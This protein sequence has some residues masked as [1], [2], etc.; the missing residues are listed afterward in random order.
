ML[1]SLQIDGNASWNPI[2]YGANALAMG[3]PKE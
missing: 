2:N 1:N 3:F